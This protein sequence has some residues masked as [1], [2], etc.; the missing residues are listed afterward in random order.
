M[1][2]QEEYCSDDICHHDDECT[3]AVPGE[4]AQHLGAE[5]LDDWMK[6]AAN[7]PNLSVETLA[8][9]MQE[10]GFSP[11]EARVL[12]AIGMLRHDTAP[13]SSILQHSRL[14]EA[15]WGLVQNFS[16]ARYGAAIERVSDK[17]LRPVP[18]PLS[19]E[20]LGPNMLARDD[21]EI[22]VRLSCQSPGIILFDNVLSSEECNA[23]IEL[24][25]E[26]M[27][28]STVMGDDGALVDPDARSSTGT[29]LVSGVSPVLDAVEARIAELVAWPIGQ[30]ERL[31]VT[32]YRP[33][34][35]FQSHLDYF[36]EDELPYHMAAIDEAGQRVGTIILYLSDVQSGGGTVFD[37]A[38]LEIRPKRGSVLYFSYQLADGSMDVASLHG[39]APVLAGEKWIATLWLRERPTSNRKANDS[40]S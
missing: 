12:A 14:Q 17:G 10:D 37:M 40:A 3:L 18:R 28:V 23:I 9:A 36:R 5:S 35:K 32:R 20:D 15:V 21:R 39:G 34:D 27:E 6:E 11:S 7:I 13:L 29:Y 4:E 8:Q 1:R 31:A 30:T 33:G 24:A 2:E 26:T 16:Q 25:R 22:T 19:A 38:G